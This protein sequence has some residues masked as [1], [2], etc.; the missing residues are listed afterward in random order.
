MVNKDVYNSNNNNN[1]KSYR[2]TSQEWMRVF[3]LV[4]TSDD[5]T[6]MRSHNTLFDPPYPKTMLHTDF[7]ALSSIEQ[8]LLL[9]KFYIADIWIFASWHLPDDLHI[10]TWPVSPEYVPTDKK[11]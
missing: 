5:L 3:S 11:K 7:T 2:Q 9:I 8:D 4:A 6:K 1:N 10:W